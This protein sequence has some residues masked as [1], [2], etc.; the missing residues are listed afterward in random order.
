MHIPM[1][2][3]HMAFANHVKSLTETIKNIGSPFSESTSEFIV[4]DIRN[5]ADLTV[6]NI[7]LKID[8]LRLNQY[9]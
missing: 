7:L 3:I 5:V 9:M 8:K 1:C 4:L 2:P 6:R